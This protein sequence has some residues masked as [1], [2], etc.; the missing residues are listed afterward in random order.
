MAVVVRTKSQ[1]GRRA[2]LRLLLHKIRSF[3]KTSSD[4][5]DVTE[6]GTKRQP[7]GP[8]GEKR[9][10][11]HFDSPGMRCVCIRPNKYIVFIPDISALKVLSV[12]PSSPASSPPYLSRTPRARPM[13]P[14]HPPK[15][16]LPLHP[17]ASSLASHAPHLQNESTRSSRTLHLP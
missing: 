14:L 11:W 15:N 4:N 5:Q 17:P 8:W 12:S 6:R 16:S 9:Q 1:S 2:R 10:R 13:A 7:S 3:F